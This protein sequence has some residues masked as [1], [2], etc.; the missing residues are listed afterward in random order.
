MLFRIGENIIF[1]FLSTTI[2]L[3]LFTE[4]H[5]AQKL[6]F[7]N[8]DIRDGLPSNVIMDI[9]QDHK[10]YMWFATQGGVSRFD[11]YHFMN[12]GIAEGL[13]F[14]YVEN[15]MEDR[16]GR[17]W[18]GTLE[19]GIAVLEK[20][21]WTIKKTYRGFADQSFLRLFEDH[22]GNIWCYPDTGIS[23]ITEKTVRYF[24][25]KDGLSNDSVA[26]HWIDNDGKILIGTY[27]GLD[28]I[29]KE[30]NNTYT[31]KTLLPDVTVNCLLRDS[32]DMLWIGTWGDGI[33]S[34]DGNTFVNYSEDK[35]SPMSKV[36]CLYI[37]QRGILWAGLM[38]S[39]IARLENDRF[40]LVTDPAISQVS[41]MDIV[42]DWH[43]TLWAQSRGE[44]VFMI[45]DGRVS[46]ITTSNNLPDMFVWKIMTDAEGNVWMG[47]GG[48][49]CKTGKKPFE[50]YDTD[51]GLPGKDV[52][53]SYVDEKNNIWG[54]TYNGPFCLSPDGSIRV[55]DERD[56]LNTDYLTTFDV[57]SDH[58]HNL[59]FGTYLGVTGY[60]GQR[61]HTFPNP[62]MDETLSVFDMA[63]CNNDT[64]IIAFD[65]GVS[66]FCNGRYIFPEAYEKLT[67]K[68]IRAICI[69]PENN[70]W[71]GTSKGIQII[72]K[73][74]IVIT[75]AEGLSNNYC[76]DIFI[77]TTGTA[78]IATD[79][80]LSK[81]VL[82]PDGSYDLVKL[83]LADGLL[84]NSIMFAVGDHAG[85][86]WIGHEKG[87]SRM[88]MA[89]GRIFTYTET[90]GFVPIETYVKAAS[91][92]VNNNVWIGTVAGLVR[93]IPMLD[94]PQLKPPRLYITDVKF[95]NDSTD[96][97]SYSS[98]S[99]SLTGL[100]GN[101]ILPYNKNNLVFKFVGL[102]Y[103]NA[104][105]NR[106]QYFL[107]GYD[108]NWSEIVA[109]TV[110]HP[111]QKLP[112]GDYT[113]RVKAANC[114]GVWSEPVSFAFSITPPFWQTGWFYALEVIVGIG[115]IYAFVKFRTRKLQ[116]DKRILEQKVKERTLEIARQRDHIA[117][118]NRE[119]T[120]S[121]LYAQRIQ[122]AVLPD[123][124]TIGSMI[125]DYFILF[126][127]RDIVSGD[128]Y[129]F[130]KKGSKIIAVAA[131]CTGHGV[132]GAF[133][134]MLGVSLL[135]EIIAECETTFTAADILNQLREY[136]KYTLSQTGKKDEAKDGMDM[137]LCVIDMANH[138]A[139]FA[140]AYNPLWHVTH[141]EMVVYKADKMPIGIHIA[142]EYTFKNNI[143]QV[144]DGDVLY[145]FSDGYAD[146]F[147]GPE[148]KKFKSGN[149]RDLVFEIHEKSMEE[150]KEIL[151][152]TIEEWRGDGPQIDDI[153]VMGIKINYQ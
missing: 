140:G 30:N 97:H 131:D 70:L 72:G 45:R 102:H 56:G 129:W 37:D 95:Y 110:T 98:F 141:H 105:K 38:E 49:I 75:A 101:L 84:S 17:I 93:Y 79:N 139:Q 3:L 69:D 2:L 6:Q 152:R 134:S 24:T 8:Y 10:G 137:A 94:Q 64:L 7:D 153:M 54:G 99:D 66:K 108:D 16:Q 1:R 34:Y 143:F 61:F 149:F 122:A 111:Y 18:V 26:C 133:M 90:D 28:L 126:K 147:G 73:H 13:P 81:I 39:G 77:D 59:W 109:E 150:Q 32:H 11:G 57:I 41:I 103:A 113:F 60:S 135:N 78:W 71:V 42:E 123:Q 115:L 33:Y 48:G 68:D 4:N 82:K 35:D 27:S 146:Q 20:G 124:E 86:L 85:N 128:F 46:K 36:A 144:N 138:E 43:H 114:D 76:N 116:H 125:R 88:E 74:N 65:G 120:D 127:P 22:D 63:V 44:G 52:F 47:T 119:I 21:K 51:F 12:Y 89:T 58:R 29:K 23:M 107:E 31:V 9:V 91:V 145:M 83:S 92:D 15:I 62:R 151:F 112:H 19:G 121:I 25:V 87:L 96:I 130:S 142:N 50:I 136:I 100:P 106:Y 148:Y 53:C 40:V 117:E 104:K 118:I 55:F 132:P 14:I 67:N 80:G 5:Y